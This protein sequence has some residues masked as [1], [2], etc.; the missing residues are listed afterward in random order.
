MLLPV[1]ITE[2]FLALILT[3]TVCSVR[4]TGKISGWSEKLSKI[5]LLFVPLYST[6]FDNDTYWMIAV[7]RN[8]IK[9][10]HD[11]I[12]RINFYSFHSIAQ[13]H[14][15]DIIFAWLDKW[16][17]RFAVVGF[18]IFCCYLGEIFVYRMMKRRISAPGIATYTAIALLE[19]YMTT[20]ALCFSSM[21]LIAEFIILDDYAHYG[22]N[23]L[24][25]I[26]LI[27]LVFINIHMALWPMQIV[28][29]G[30][31]IAEWIIRRL[32]K[33]EECFRILPILGLI[34]LMLGASFLNPYGLEGF[35][36]PFGTYTHDI[37]FITE[38]H[39]SFQTHPIFIMP[40]LTVT[41]YIFASKDVLHRI[42]F[43]SASGFAGTFLM[44]AKNLRHISL[45][46]VAA[47]SI[48]SETLRGYPL[49]EASHFEKRAAQ[50]LPT[51]ICAGAIIYIGGF[52][53][54][55]TVSKYKGA[56]DY[57]K[58]Q[59]EEIRPYTSL[60]TGGYAAYRGIKGYMD[61]RTEPH[62]KNYNHQFDWFN[63]YLDVYYGRKP[64][65]GLIRKYHFNYVVLDKSTTYEKRYFKVHP[66][67][68]SCVYHDENAEV[69]RVTE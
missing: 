64:I 22:R 54:Y 50:I 16:G 29:L 61:A 55:L 9:Y 6:N 66:W 3:D 4:K 69:W 46:P 40:L 26:P 20:R 33:K 37:S 45:T 59:N 21:L 48:V 43:S 63:E 17:G 13:Q 1:L 49:G 8:L 27:S 53:H 2:V 30:T 36:Y 41:I 56:F 62:Y 5:M 19:P 58:A 39:S 15:L 32:R 57:L 11:G 24:F 23:R 18:T 60:N 44:A 42:S 14:T 28:F 7:G 52:S 38:L 67:T 10:G 51:I 25:I 34:P 35:L 47:S 31:F 65:S 68:A 12:D